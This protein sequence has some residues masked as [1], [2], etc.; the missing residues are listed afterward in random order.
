MQ[1][2]H[3]SNENINKFIDANKELGKYYNS[4]KRVVFGKNFIDFTQ[5]LAKSLNAFFD[6]TIELYIKLNIDYKSSRFYSFYIDFIE[7]EPSSKVFTETPRVS[8]ADP[9]AIDVI[10]IANTVNRMFNYIDTYKNSLNIIKSDKFNILFQDFFLLSFTYYDFSFSQN[11]NNKKTN[12]ALGLFNRF[13]YDKR[14]FNE[15]RVAMENF[16]RKK[17]AKEYSNIFSRY[18]LQLHI[19]YIYDKYKENTGLYETSEIYDDYIKIYEEEKDSKMKEKIITH[20][21]FTYIL[22]KKLWRIER[23]FQST[24]EYINNI[25]YN[26]TY[27]DKIKEYTENYLEKVGKFYNAEINYGDLLKE[28]YSLDKKCIEEFVFKELLEDIN[29]N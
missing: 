26:K 15:N 18:L 5:A 6:L 27:S 9:I 14:F 16:I 24:P 2:P 20:E 13:A 19:N 4:D 21:I 23:I 17:G 28:M 1:N 10:K 29:D 25:D 11:F 22:A 7:S 8:I 12:G 3:Y